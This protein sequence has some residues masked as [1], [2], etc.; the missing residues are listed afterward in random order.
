M[1]EHDTPVGLTEIAARLGVR[2]QSAQNWRT[3][4]VLPAPRWTVGG[5]PAWSWERDICPWAAATGRLTATKENPMATTTQ[6]QPSLRIDLHDYAGEH[7]E[8]F[9][10]DAV[11]ADFV[12]AVNEAAPEGFWV[13]PAGDIYAEVDRVDD[14]PDWDELLRRIDPAP[15]FQR[16][17]VTADLPSWVSG[18]VRLS[19]T[20]Q[21]DYLASMPQLTANGHRAEAIA[22]TVF[23]ALSRDA[24]D[25]LG[26]LEADHDGYYDGT[27]IWIGGTQYAVTAI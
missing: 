22:N 15:I 5:G 4:G 25:V 7:A 2:Q 6:L 19:S 23:V 17:D 27:H 24:L 14:A 10:M 8:H 1:T 13:S 20:D 9:D 21:V 16:H 26:D 3:R 18:V 12:A 11:H